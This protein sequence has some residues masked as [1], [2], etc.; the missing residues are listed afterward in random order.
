MSLIVLPILYYQRIGFFFVL[1]LI[2][3]CVIKYIY[4]FFAWVFYIPE[5]WR[6]RLD[7]LS[8]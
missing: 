4:R 7:V 3:K 5:I 1:D 8:I 2:A 6:S